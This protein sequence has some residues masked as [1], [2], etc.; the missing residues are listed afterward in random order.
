MLIKGISTSKKIKSNA[1]LFMQF[2]A[3]KALEKSP[4]EF[5]KVDS[6]TNLVMVILLNSAI[7]NNDTIQFHGLILFAKINVEQLI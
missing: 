5:N 1:L 3:S 2:F 7:I 6:L 4:I